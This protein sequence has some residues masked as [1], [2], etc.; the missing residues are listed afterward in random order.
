MQLGIFVGGASSRMGQPKGL[1]RYEGSTLLDHA[2]S[3][4]AAL[5]L[6][7]VLVGDA[8]PYDDHA[9]GVRRCPDEVPGVGAL[10]GLLPLL[11]HGPALVMAC[12]MPLLQ[13]S[14]L[15]SLIDAPK[16]LIALSRTESFYE[17]FPAR[18]DPGLCAVIESQL[19]QS[20]TSFQSLLRALTPHQR[21]LV[22]L[23]RD[24]T[25]DWDHPSDVFEERPEH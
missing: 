21:V 17:P 6:E 15:Q 13:T 16:A 22:E 3:L 24:A 19:A 10:G 9:P 18:C 2:L 14:H 11:R 1:L 25:L 12:D 20:R 5:N 8:S 4:A 7:P 23:P